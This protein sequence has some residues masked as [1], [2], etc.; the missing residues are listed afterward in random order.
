MPLDYGSVANELE[1]RVARMEQS[2]MSTT[3]PTVDV[4]IDPD[5]GAT[6]VAD[7]LDWSVAAGGWE[8]YSQIG[9]I[10]TDPDDPNYPGGELSTSY[11][12][13][14]VQLLG[15]MCVLSGMVRRKTGALPNPLAAGTRYNIPMFGLPVDW[16]PTRNVILPCLMGNTD[17]TS[18]GANLVGTAWVEIRPE[19]NPVL[20]SS[21]R[22]YFVTG[23]LSCPPSTGWIALQGVFPC[24]L[25]GST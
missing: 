18:L 21:G 19:V 3:A 17:P 12:M 2:T 11:G 23:T 15:S 10:I 6:V 25:F 20:R 8:S 24:Q 7:P 4:Y 5:S 9:P 16:R 22:A 14:E 1:S 13:A